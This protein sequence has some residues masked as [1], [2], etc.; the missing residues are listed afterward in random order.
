MS[1]FW[2]GSTQRTRKLRADVHY[3]YPVEG[4][5]GFSTVVAVPTSAQNVDLAKKFMSFVMRP[6]TAGK[7]S[8]LLNYQ[9]AV[10]GSEK[11]MDAEL[12]ASPEMN[13][14]KDRKITF[15][16][17]CPAAAIKLQDRLWTNLMK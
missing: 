1:S 16:Q 6:E 14:P 3:A 4:V 5:L 9:N 8:N 10:K 17:T 15:T 2:S 12:S 11:F 7:T 13:V